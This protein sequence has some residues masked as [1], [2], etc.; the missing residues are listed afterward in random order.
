MAL[1]RG[2][3]QMAFPDLTDFNLRT[4]RF[5]FVRREFAVNSKGTS[6]FRITF[7]D[8]LLLGASLR[9]SS[10]LARNISTATVFLSKPNSCAISS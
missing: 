4:Y 9:R 7:H 10:C 6:L 2:F 5:E 3:A 8:H 1:A